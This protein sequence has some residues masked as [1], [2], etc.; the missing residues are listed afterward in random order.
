MV[1]RRFHAIR[2]VWAPYSKMPTLGPPFSPTVFMK[3]T[4]G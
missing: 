3:I 1:T 2:R 4:F